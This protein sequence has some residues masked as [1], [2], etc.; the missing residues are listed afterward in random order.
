MENLKLWLLSVG[1]AYVVTSIFRIIL[2]DRYKKSVNVFLSL[3]VLFYTV[4][5]INQIIKENKNIINKIEFQ[6]ETLEEYYEKSYVEILNKIILDACNENKVELLSLNIKSDV[7]GNDF[8]IES[9]DLVIDK[10]SKVEHIKKYIKD[11]FNLEV[12]VY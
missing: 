2:N 11:K 10:K 6:N 1:G 9:I 7:D 8:I 4:F 12:N 5:P 3:F